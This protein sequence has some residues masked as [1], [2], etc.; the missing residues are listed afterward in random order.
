MA[1]V[2][3]R[4]IPG[5]KASDELEGGKRSYTRVFRVITDS[6]LASALAVGL[7]A[8]LPQLGD[9]HT[10]QDGA[11]DETVKCLKVSP[12]QDSENPQVWTVDIEYGPPTKTDEQQNPNPLLRPAVISYSFA[13]YQRAC[14][15]DINGKAIRNAANDWFDPCPEIDDSRPV[16]SITRNEPIFNASL[17]IAYQDAVNSDAFLGA[18]PGQV[19]VSGISARNQTENNYSFWEVTYELEFRREGWQ[20]QLL[21]QGRNS[22]WEDGSLLPIPKK[23][24][25]ADGTIGWQ[26]GTQVDE[27]VPLG[28]HGLPLANP[29][30]DTC[31]YLPFTVYKSL[32]FAPLGLP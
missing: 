4:E 18:Q 30:P 15:N 11:I 14:Y 28:E 13:K 20:L 5:G 2:S 8:D 25:N 26:E 12:Q 22:L 1:I 19:K 31:V 29:T 21:N 32:A 16:V 24:K 23:G 6:G 7:A 17:A 3:V 10:A 9:P 27:P